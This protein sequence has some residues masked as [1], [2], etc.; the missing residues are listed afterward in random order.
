MKRV[1]VAIPNGDM[2][3]TFLPEYVQKELEKHFEVVYN[4]GTTQYTEEEFA[5][6]LKDFD[7][8]MTDWYCKGLKKGA[9]EGNDRLKLI[10]HT[11]GTVANVLDGYAY[12]KGITVLSGNIMY[13]ESV[14][15][16][17][18]AYI[19]MALRRLPDYIGNTRNGKWRANS[20]TW[21]GLF[22]RTV[23]II[24][25][26]AIGRNVVKLLQPY[27][28]KIK[29]YAHY[30]IEQE[31]L[32]QY[33][34]EVA[35]LEEIFSTCDIVSLHSALNDQTTGMIK[36]EHF[37]SMKDG[38][39]FVNTARGPIIEE[40]GMI[41]ELRKK[42]IRAVLD[43]FV[44]EPL[45][46]DHELRSMENVYVIP[47]MAGPTLDRREHITKALIGEMVGF[48]EGKTGSPF[49]ITA[50]MAKLMTRHP[51]KKA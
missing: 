8:V 30:E 51:A 34:C 21:E 23:G 43:V 22:D 33:H 38:A 25:L 45:P 36:G 37:A 14:A 6:L 47:H 28:V 50:D 39:L 44:Q 11:G 32:D 48:F 24:G 20:D 19:M 27:R 7:A 40:E 3:E 29:I 12:E 46:A 4:P 42:R 13:A 1:L 9:L 31:F 18:L 5:G 10:V 49:E 15:E 26:G 2:K 17:T 16:G 41:E 35:S